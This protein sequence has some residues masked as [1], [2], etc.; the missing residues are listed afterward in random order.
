MDNEDDVSVRIV[1]GYGYII[2]YFPPPPRPSPLWCEE[3]EKTAPKNDTGFDTD[4]R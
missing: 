2:F 4:C 3:D 1:C